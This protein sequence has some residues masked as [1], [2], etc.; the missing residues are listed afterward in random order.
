MLSATLTASFPPIISF[1][2]S[3][4]LKIAI[5]YYENGQWISQ[6][7]S[8]LRVVPKRQEL[9][10][11]KSLK[12]SSFTSFDK[13]VLLNQPLRQREYYFYI[14]IDNRLPEYGGGFLRYFYSLHH[15]YAIGS[16]RPC[17]WLEYGDFKKYNARYSRNGL[18]RFC[19][20]VFFGGNWVNGWYYV[21]VG[22]ASDYTIEFKLSQHSHTHYHYPHPH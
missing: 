9:L 7:W 4:T 15:K 1:P 19:D 20:N 21:D 14:E 10:D 16:Y 11:L 12:L 6:G 5:A 3:Y 17:F 22:N 2:G 18:D 13:V 8:H